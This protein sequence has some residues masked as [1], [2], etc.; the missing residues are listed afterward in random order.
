MNR[1]GAGLFSALLIAVLVGVAHS[2]VVIGIKVSPHI[3]AMRSNAEWITVH[4]TLRYSLAETSTIALNEIPVV[5]AFADDRGNLVAKFRMADVRA[6][7][8]PPS[9][10]LTLTGMTRD[11]EPFT[12]SETVE[13]KR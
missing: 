2:E 5:S 11:S 9:A 6:I 8:A 7:V 10:T 3:I 4:T 1:I 13:V 12:G